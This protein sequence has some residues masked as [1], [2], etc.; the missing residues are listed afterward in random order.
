MT[1]GVVAHRR[2][3]TNAPLVEAW[4]RLGVDARLLTP[5]EAV[6]VL[7]PMDIALIRL[8]VL[9][10]LN[11][12]EPGLDHVP[13]LRFKG[14][15]ILNAPWALVGVHDKLETA[16]RLSATQIPHPRT[17][18]V[19]RPDDEVDV[20]PPVVVKPRY[21]SWGQDVYLCKSARALRHRLREVQERA[22]F[23][24][25]G[26]LVQELIRSP[27]R[28]LRVIVAGGRVV[29]AAARTARTGEWRTNVSL[30]GTIEPCVPDVSA[31][32]LAL[33]A[34]GAI[35]CDLVGVDL[36]PA[37][38]GYVVL[39]LNGAVDFDERYS[40]GGVPAYTATA[41][42]LGLVDM[43]ETREAS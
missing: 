24:S 6:G 27:H 40:F 43:L 1:V 19:L 29:G 38:D 37:D 13:E 33:A 28:D 41:T 34:A 36:L 15:E 17:A 4:Q 23:R 9:R 22:W 5:D 32:R 20:V 7:G 8:D 25:H 21:G 39:E 3:P 12:I 2:G 42:A 30:G 31:A 18:H 26:A 16:R 11:G 10:A 14:V 35:G